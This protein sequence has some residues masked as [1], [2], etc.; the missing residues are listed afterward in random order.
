MAIWY[1]QYGSRVVS[2]WSAGASTL[3]FT[4]SSG[5][6]AMT[7]AS[8][9]ATLGSS[10]ILVANGQTGLAIDA[11][12]VCAGIQ[13]SGSA[14]GASGTDGGGFT[15]AL[16]TVTQT[17]AINVTASSTSCLTATGATHA[18]TLGALQGGGS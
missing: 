16:A 9:A 4:A 11:N 18:L 1:A 2:D 14:N 15:I 13:T 7:G 10:D 8:F 17:T 3:W 12:L 6:T 5:G